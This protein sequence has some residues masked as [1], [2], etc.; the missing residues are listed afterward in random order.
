MKFGG[1][2]VG[3]AARIA[4]AARLADDTAQELG[5]GSVVVVVS[6]MAGVTNSLREIG[7]LAAEGDTEGYRQGIEA[8]RQK[9][10]AVADALL[11]GEEQAQVRAFISKQADEALTLCEGLSVVGELTLRALDR[12]SGIGR[13]S[14]PPCWPRPARPGPESDLRGCHPG[15]GH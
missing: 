14:R 12:I 8:L 4:H 3:D 5:D 9:H 15:R 11:E 6:A 10:F 2:S 1:T 13:S 7:R